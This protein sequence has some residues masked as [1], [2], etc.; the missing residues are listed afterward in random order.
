MAH[1]L[2]VA[3]GEDGVPADDHAGERPRPRLGWVTP[4][5]GG[6]RV[7]QRKLMHAVPCEVEDAPRVGMKRI[8][9]VAGLRIDDDTAVV[10]AFHEALAH[11]LGLEPGARQGRE[12]RPVLQIR[13]A[14]DERGGRERVRGPRAELADL[15]LPHHPRRDGGRFAVGAPAVFQQFPRETCRGLVDEQHGVARIGRAFLQARRQEHLEQ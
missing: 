8:D 12:A 10:A 11:P 9:D 14:H 13:I 3:G 7:G 6:R 15:Q 2:D 5:G 1:L 4:G